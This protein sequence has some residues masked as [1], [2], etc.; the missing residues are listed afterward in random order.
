MG[1][2]SPKVRVRLFAL[3]RERAG[4]SALEVDLPPQATVSALL[5]EIARQYPQVSPHLRN[6]LV[7]VNQEYVDREHPLGEGDEVAL[8]P[9]V[10]GGVGCLS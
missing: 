2:P 7:A 6:V 4:C 5:D 3:L 1:L 10:S 9:P 8:I